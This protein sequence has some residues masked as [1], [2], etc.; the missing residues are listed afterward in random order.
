MII[1]R[2]S[3]SKKKTPTVPRNFEK[4]YRREKVGSENYQS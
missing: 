2:I 1:N 4:R 3:N